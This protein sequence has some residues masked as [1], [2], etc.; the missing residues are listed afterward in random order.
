MRVLSRWNAPKLMQTP[1]DH[2]TIAIGIL[3]ELE[4]D[5]EKWVTVFGKDH[6]PRTRQSE[7]TMRRKVISL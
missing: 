7:M 1:K 2:V 6:A 3:T 4:H 5:P